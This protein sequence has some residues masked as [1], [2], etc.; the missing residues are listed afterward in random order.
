V[1]VEDVVDDRRR[2]EALFR[3]QMEHRLRTSLQIIAGWA[4]TLDDAWEQLP[5]Q[6]RREGV[7]VLRRATEDLTDQTCRLLQ[8]TRAELLALDLH[9][10]PIDLGTILAAAAQF[11]DGCSN[12]HRVVHA[13][14]GGQV[15]VEVDGRAL[16]E[17][18]A[19]LVD[20]A[21]RYSPPA[22]D[23]VL[24][25]LVDAGDGTVVLEVIDQGVGVPD[26]IDLFAPFQRGAG[27]RAPG[28]GLGLYLVRNLVE[29]MGGSIAARRND[30]GPGSTLSVRLPAV[31]EEID[32]RW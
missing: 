21:V 18:L 32:G 10:A 29:A 2:D 8:Q 28:T 19:H 22:T 27:A 13:D 14:P 16:H 3:A 26:D 31:P 4:S 24:R 12:A 30:S 11:L 1:D 25:G 23:I 5:E 15:I 17:V 7:A 6:R 9:P 20:N